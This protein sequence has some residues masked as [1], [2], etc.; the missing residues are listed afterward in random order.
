MNLNPFSKIYQ[1][2][3]KA[4]ISAEEE[5]KRNQ[6]RSINDKFYLNE[7]NGKI[8]IVCNGTAVYEA[9]PGE[10]ASQ[11][12]EKLEKMRQTANVYSTINEN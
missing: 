1:A 11:L 3:K 5:R 4:K 10:Q 6:I 2:Y 9:Q 12:V 8:Y 7:F